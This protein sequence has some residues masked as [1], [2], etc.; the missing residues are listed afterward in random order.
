M[1]LDVSLVEKVGFNPY[2][3][4]KEK[5]DFI[6]LASNNYLGL[7][8]NCRSIE[9][10]IAATREYG[11]SLCGTP[12]ATGYIDLFRK[13]EQQLSSFV[14]L[15]E[16]IL[17]PS[18]YQANNGI[19]A[20]L[21]DEES[22]IVIDRYAHS[23]LMQGVMAAKAKI[24]PFLHN[25]I[26]HLEKIL[27]RNV[28]YQKI[29]VVTESVFSTEGSIV[30]LDEII[31]LCRKFDAIPVVDDSHGIGVLGKHGKGVLEYFGVDDFPGIYT[32]SL[33]KAIAGSGGMVSGKKHIIE[34]LRHYCPQLIYSTAITPGILGGIVGALDVIERDFDILKGKMWHYKDRISEVLPNESKGQTPI[35]SVLT[36]SAEATLMLSKKL[37]EHKILSTPFIEPSVPKNSGVVRLIAGAGLTEE[38]VD[39]AVV[40]IQECL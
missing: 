29:F 31:Y 19:F 5:R 8:Q 24:S 25:D 1:K 26:D 11:T 23:S 13:V 20:L 6:D 18:C 39:Q 9:A 2:Y 16:T 15:E 28:E 7:A 40:G 38:Q 3:N 12:I 14:G 35:H 36:G 33:G 34:F 27:S 37:Y 10:S 22:L 30:P 4:A 17:F 21:V 32:A